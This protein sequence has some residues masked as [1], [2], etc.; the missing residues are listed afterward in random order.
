MLQYTIDK[1]V[2]PAKY[3]K[4][5]LAVY[6]YPLTDLRVGESFKTEE[7]Y[8]KKSASRVRGRINLIKKHSQLSAD[9]SVAKDPESE[10]VRVWRVR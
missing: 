10:A 6:D 2:P 4:G 3:A 9:F 7:T 5:K 1:N 8:D